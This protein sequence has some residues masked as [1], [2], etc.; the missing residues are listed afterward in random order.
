L[1]IQSLHILG[2]GDSLTAGTPGFEPSLNW[3]DVEYQYGFWLVKEATNAGF[4]QPT[5]D[6]R[7]IPGELAQTMLP[8]LTA[9]LGK[10]KFDV[11]IILGGSNDIGWGR[12]VAEIFTDLK[13]LWNEAVNQECQVIACTVPPIRARFPPIQGAQTELNRLIREQVLKTDS[14]FVVDTFQELSDSKGLLRSKYDSGDGLHL[15]KL[16]YRT[17]GEV[18]WRKALYEILQTSD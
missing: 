12:E 5:F 14:I 17:M 10:T 4:P 3:G 2:F 15:N 8:R 1:C 16:G 11:V 18:I 7:G 13:S 6:N 9:I